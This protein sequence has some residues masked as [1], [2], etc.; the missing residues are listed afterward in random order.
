LRSLLEKS[1]VDL[2]P[3][4]ADVSEA[5]GRVLSTQEQ[6]SEAEQMALGLEHPG[7]D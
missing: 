1:R 2:Y 5:V 3:S 4:L 7:T 6:L